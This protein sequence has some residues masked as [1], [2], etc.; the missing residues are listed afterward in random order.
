MPILKPAN[1]E[2]KG[3]C[4][5]HGFCTSE[6]QQDAYNA[7]LERIGAEGVFAKLAPDSQ[8]VLYINVPFAGKFEE[9]PV[10]VNFLRRE[11][12]NRR[13]EIRLIRIFVTDVQDFFSGGQAK[14][15]Y[16]PNIW[17]A[18]AVQDGRSPLPPAHLTLGMHPD[19]SSRFLTDFGEAYHPYYFLWQR[20]LFNNFASSQCAV[21]CNLWL[22]EAIEV[23]NVAKQ[24]GMVAS[25]A[26][27]NAI[28]YGETLTAPLTGN[29]RDRR[30]FHYITISERLPLQVVPKIKTTEEDYTGPYHNMWTLE[31]RAREAAK[32]REMGA[33]RD[34]DC[35]SDS[36]S[37]SSVGSD[38]D[39]E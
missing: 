6:E 16:D 31:Q 38:E 18:Y 24:A 14:P 10:L 15:S 7:V 20:I 11:V 36:D 3:S 33:L 5:D 2:R 13:P 4:A 8:G 27:K 32:L 1:T 30:P 39:V 23:Q 37:L 21:F 12:L 22:E 19:C 17:I 35:D 28:Y 9:R 34:T 29:K 26:L 25:A